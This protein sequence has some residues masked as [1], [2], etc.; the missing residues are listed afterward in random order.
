MIST[1][2]AGLLIDTVVCLTLAKWETVSGRLGGYL[3]R[4]AAHPTTRSNLPP[5]WYTRLLGMWQDNAPRACRTAT[6][7]HQSRRMPIPVRVRRGSRLLDCATGVGRL[8]WRPN[9]VTH[10]AVTEASRCYSPAAVIAKGRLG[11]L[12]TNAAQS[13]SKSPDHRNTK[14]H[15][16]KSGRRSS[17]R[18]HRSNRREHP[19]SRRWGK[20]VEH[21]GRSVCTPAGE[22]GGNVHK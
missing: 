11:Q 16:S 2:S 13:Q 7:F 1:R 4:Y 9:S 21:S 19:S 22:L 6:D 3:T 10:L 17:T 15:R 8:S 18:G 12:T 14:E 5:S 20:P